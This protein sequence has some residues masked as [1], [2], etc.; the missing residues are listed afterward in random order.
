[1][2]TPADQTFTEVT[3]VAEPIAKPKAAKPRKAGAA[4]GKAKDAK[5]RKPKAAATK[6]GVR[7]VKGSKRKAKEGQAA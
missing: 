5:S 2:P 1:M 6:A 7:M 4:K 3:T